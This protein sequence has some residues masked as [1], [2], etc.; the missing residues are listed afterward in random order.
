MV[1]PPKKPKV[2][3]PKKEVTP[4]ANTDVLPPASLARIL[5]PQ[6]AT[7]WLLPYVST[8]TPQYIEQVLKNALAGNHVQQWQLFDLMLDTWPELAACQTELTDAVMGMQPV[9]SPWQDEDATA[10][11]D[12]LLRRKLV[13][14]AVRG[15]R[16]RPDADEN[17]FEGTVKDLV[18]GWFRGL[19]LL[20]IEWHMQTDPTLGQFMAPR[21]TTWVH[22]S[23]YAWGV[24]G[25]LGLRA[26]AFGQIEQTASTNSMMPTNVAQLPPNK[27]LVGLHKSKSGSPLGGA[28]LR[29]LCWWWCA[30]NFAADWVLNL[31]Q[32]FGIPF[33]WANYDPTT[34]QSTVD[35][36]CAMLQNMGSAGYGAFPTGTSLQFQ[37]A[38]KGSDHSPQGELLDRADRYARLVILGQTMSGTSGTTGKGGGQAFGQVEAEIKAAR[39]DSC[40]KYVARVLNNQL[41]TAILEL[42]YG[43][44]AM[45]PTVSFIPRKEAST[46]EAQRDLALAKVIDIPVSFFRS[47]YELPTPGEGD[48]IAG[49]HAE[50]DGDEDPEEIEEPE[51]AVSARAVLADLAA[52]PDDDKFTRALARLAADLK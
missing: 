1:L 13:S 48:E 50:P 14:C 9:F 20:E 49:R 45:A 40:A 16:P 37:D 3:F 26:N 18:D 31:A 47:K 52:E 43:E 30:A 22:P 11:A 2:P 42:N 8:I 21:C 46:A 17:D 29:P 36:I 38:G 4:A 12:A 27:F 5:R 24:D 23:D 34:P 41:V 32:L 6:A 28:L 33:R 10:D 25:S 19:T 15:M 44:T 39:A 7:R 51:E 35:S